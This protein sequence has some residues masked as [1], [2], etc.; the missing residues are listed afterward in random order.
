MRRLRSAV[1]ASAMTIAIAVAVT[2]PPALATPAEGDIER[3]DLAKGTTDAPIAIVS[4][5]QPTTLHVQNLLL[6]P[7]STSG[8]H[9]H[10]GP[11][12]SAINAGTVTLQTAGSCAPAVFAAGQAIFVPA[13]I[14]HVVSNNAFEHAEA[15]VTYTLPA[16]R[17]VR[18]DAPAA[19]P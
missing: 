17:A 13:G 16:D 5:G 3:T 15:T 11:E 6:A 18:D 14:P 12:Y 4:V 9:T 10:P 1:T 8:W 7:A 2:P 19:C